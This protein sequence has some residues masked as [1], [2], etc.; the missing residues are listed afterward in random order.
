LPELKDQELRS[1]FES[2]IEAWGRAP[3]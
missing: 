1:A 3:R 2:L